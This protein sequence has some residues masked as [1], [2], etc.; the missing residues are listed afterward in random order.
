MAV[1]IVPPYPPTER[2]RNPHATAPPTPMRMSM[3]GPYPLPSK[4]LPVPHPTTSPMKIHAIKNI[5]SSL[6]S[7]FVNIGADWACPCDEINHSALTQL[8]Q[9]RSCE[10][11]NSLPRTYRLWEFLRSARPAFSVLRD[12]F[13]G[14][15]FPRS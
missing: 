13:R 6:P 3:N 14:C 8:R 7:Q 10:R 2:I 4:T 9:R 11:L 12:T 1:T 5:H 15:R